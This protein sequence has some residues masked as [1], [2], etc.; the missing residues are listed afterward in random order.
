MITVTPWEESTL[1]GILKVL[2]H[3]VPEVLKAILSR[4][5]SV[6]KLNNDNEIALKAP[7]QLFE[8]FPV[9]LQHLKEACTK[10]TISFEDILQL[11]VNG[12]AKL[13]HVAA[14]IGNLEALQLIASRGASTLW[15]RVPFFTD[16]AHMGREEVN[17]LDI[18]TFNLHI[19]VIYALLLLGY[20]EKKTSP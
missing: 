1:T 2:N 11:T 6:L 17:A 16:N 10:D 20:N 12:G 15:E 7:K 3:G 4:R 13:A 14:A 9:L 19:S 8:D 18:A 5:D